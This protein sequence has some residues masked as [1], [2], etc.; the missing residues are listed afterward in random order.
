[1]TIRP[2]LRPAWTAAC[3]LGFAFGT[4]AIA[5]GHD[6]GAAMLWGMVR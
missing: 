3:L 5:H 6:H 4:Y 1:M 2:L